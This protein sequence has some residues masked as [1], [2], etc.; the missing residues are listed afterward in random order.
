MYTR[1]LEFVPDGKGSIARKQTI[2][3]SSLV[4]NLSYKLLATIH[5]TVATNCSC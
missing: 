5:P 4:E 3:K 1:S 2:L